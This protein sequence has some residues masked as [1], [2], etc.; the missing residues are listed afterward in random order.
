MNTSGNTAQRMGTA[1]IMN[2]TA[3]LK[4]LVAAIN[5][6]VTSGN[7]DIP[8]GKTKEEYT[9]LMQKAHSLAFDSINVADHL[10]RDGVSSATVEGGIPTET[11][12]NRF[13]SRV[14]DLHRSKRASLV[15]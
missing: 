13:A 9:R 8:E 15:G 5:S 3:R 12:Q 7:S 11:L 1:N 6:F 14:A 2:P 10:E 4:A